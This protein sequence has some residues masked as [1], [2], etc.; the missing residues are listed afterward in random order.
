MDE[1]VKESDWLSDLAASCGRVANHNPSG[2][3][4]EIRFAIQRGTWT[5]S[6]A[7]ITKLAVGTAR[8]AEKKKRFK[9]RSIAGA[10]SSHSA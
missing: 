6:A 2:S 10:G 3:P 8:R 4:G 1:K 7:T 9:I 5:L